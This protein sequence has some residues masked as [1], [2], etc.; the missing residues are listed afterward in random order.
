M[1]EDH[2]QKPESVATCD[3]IEHENPTDYGDGDARVAD[4]VK[5]MEVHRILSGFWGN[6]S[7]DEASD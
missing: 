1:C 5:L 2:K 6:F 3:R 7:W 4:Q